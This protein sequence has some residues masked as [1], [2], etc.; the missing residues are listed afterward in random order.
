MLQLALL[1]VL[2]DEA[3]CTTL[4][5]FANMPRMRTVDNILQR[6]YFVAP[7]QLLR[8]CMVK[9][10]FRAFEE[11]YVVHASRLFRSH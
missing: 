6:S 11:S 5:R 3:Q 1:K 4:I 7:Q 8:M 9:V 10:I 2:L